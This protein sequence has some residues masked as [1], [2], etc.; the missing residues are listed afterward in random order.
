MSFL[1]SII[2]SCIIVALKIIVSFVKNYPK[3]IKRKKTKQTMTKRFFNPFY[4]EEW[5][6]SDMEQRT[7]GK[8]F[9]DRILHRIFCFLLL[10]FFSGINS[11]EFWGRSWNSLHYMYSLIDNCDHKD[12]VRQSHCKDKGDTFQRRSHPLTSC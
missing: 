6:N 9:G 10:W 8:N 3:L 12:F 1:Q 7:V 2:R 4:N 5:Q 11:L